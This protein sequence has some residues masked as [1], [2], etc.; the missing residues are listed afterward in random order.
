[1]GPGL[2]S[3]GPGQRDARFPLSPGARGSARGAAPAGVGFPAPAAA[4]CSVPHGPAPPPPAAGSA[5][6]RPPPA[7]AAGHGAEP[8]RGGRAGPGGRADPRTR[9]WM[10]HSA[11]ASLPRY[12]ASEGQARPARPRAR[13]RGP[14]LQRARIRRAPLTPAP[15]SGQERRSEGTEVEENWG[16]R[17]KKSF[18]LIQRGRIRGPNQRGRG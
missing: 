4:D 1:M 6:P 18:R 2:E 13:P 8:L 14:R 10:D 3:R 17:R 16:A 5:A 9:G 11:A 15:A 7:A 12:G